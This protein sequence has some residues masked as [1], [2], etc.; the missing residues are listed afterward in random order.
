[1]TGRIISIEDIYYNRG[2]IL[3]NNSRIQEVLNSF[4]YLKSDSPHRKH[5]PVS[6]GF[7]LKVGQ[8]NVIHGPSG[9]GKSSILNI[10]KTEIGGVEI[11]DLPKKDEYIINMV[12]RDL[13]EA[14]SILMS[15]GLGEG[16]L[17]I[18]KCSQLSDGQKFRMRIALELN[19]AILDKSP[20]VLFIDEFGSNLDLI[21][22]VA[23]AK[24]FSKAVKKT[25]L[26][27]F[28]CCN[29][30]KVV[31]AF[32]FDSLITL[33]YDHMTEVKYRKTTRVKDNMKINIQKGS[34]GHYERFKRFHYLDIGERINDAQ[35]YIAELEGE[36]LGV[37]VMVQ[38]IKEKYARLDPYFKLINEKMITI[39]RMVVHPEFRSMGIGRTLAEEAP[40]LAGF[41]IV[42]TRSAMFHFA[43]VPI[44]WGF[45]NAD[46]YFDELYWKDRR[47]NRNLEKFMFDNGRYP[48]MM[49]DDDYC[50]KFLQK[51]DRSHLT[52]LIFEDTREQFRNLISYFQSVMDKCGFPYHGDVENLMKK[53]DYIITEPKTEAEIVKGLKNNKQVRYG[54]FYL[55]LLNK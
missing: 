38:P 33:G 52:K 5:I 2:V 39:Y 32:D 27:I 48:S 51:V 19:A 55:N 23:I 54:A 49:V 4:H 20:Q 46:D 26:T 14:I 40:K 17:F 37:S 25:N 11:T 41:D 8:I 3:P 36:I 30:M 21:S 16:N 13:K 7:E 29:N 31:E 18:R 15:A 47:S 6:S 1:M 34:I 44:N 45:K 9:S 43:P 12:G 24:T 35:I 53:C 10:L 22:A 28:V 42:E 50:L